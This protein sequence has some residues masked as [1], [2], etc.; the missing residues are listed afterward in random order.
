MVF[1]H[2]TELSLRAAVHLANSAE[3]PDTLTS[4]TELN[5]FWEQFGYT[6]R[7]DRD[8]AELDAVR[9]LR[10]RLRALMTAERDEAVDIVNDLLD[11]AG[12]VPRLVRH[13]HFDWHLHVVDPETPLDQRIAA[14][15]AMAMIDVIRADEMSRLGIC[16]SA[17]LR[18]ASSSTC[19]ATGRRSCGTTCSNRGRRRLPRAQPLIGAL[20]VVVARKSRST[21]VKA[22]GCSLCTQCPEP[23]MVTLRT[24]GN[25]AA[26]ASACSS[27]T[28]SDRS[29]RTQS[30]R[31]AVR[32]QAGHPLRGPAGDH[33]EAVAD[34]LE[35]RL[36]VPP[37]AVLR[38]AQV[39]KQEAADDRVGNGVGQ[40]PFGV[41]PG[42]Q[43]PSRSSPRIATTY[44]SKECALS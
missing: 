2:D 39:L 23:L 30:T 19:P 31:A 37:G 17:R 9:R 36:P 26:I 11:K 33:V 3:P 18:R 27:A 34:D 13:D 12:A 40:R 6:G 32:R 22:S 25:R 8:D 41:G 16:A 42:G 28:C 29:P 15:T 14:E 1:A 4:M 21:L 44:R 43:R 7:H 35:V 38:A 24:R 20:T 10:P 5:A